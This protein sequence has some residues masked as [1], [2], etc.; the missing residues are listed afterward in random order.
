MGGQL[1][2]RC[3]LGV[4]SNDKTHFENLPKEKQPKEASNC[5]PISEKDQNWSVAGNLKKQSYFKV[6]VL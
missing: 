2:A 1:F 6:E 4:L 5:K 3:C